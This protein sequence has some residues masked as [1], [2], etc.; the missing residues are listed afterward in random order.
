MAIMLENEGQM[1]IFPLRVQRADVPL[2]LS[3]RQHIA[4]DADY[5]RGL[6]GLLAALRPGE[7]PAAPAAP[8]AP[9]PASIQTP[10]TAK[11]ALP[12][13]IIDWPDAPNQELALNRPT[14]T[15][16]RAPENDI[17]LDLPIV[18]SRHLRLDVDDN[19][20][21]PRVWLTDLGSRN[22]TFLSGRRLPAQ[23]RQMLEPGDV[24]N[25][26]D[27]AGRAI[28][29]ILHPGYSPSA[30]LP[31]PAARPAMTATAADVL[32]ANSPAAAISSK[33]PAPLARVP[34][35]A[36]AAAGLLSLIHI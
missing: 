18:S 19:S 29:L 30:P 26:G 10:V 4:F 32:P 36:Y 27:R 31:L 33:L 20:G 28:S 6:A 35:W 11:A 9:R 5:D 14:I 15:V 7:A 34:L 24:V 25:L 21:V 22:G 1:R 2:L 17:V 8:A 23:T 13:L 12:V 16:G 3:T